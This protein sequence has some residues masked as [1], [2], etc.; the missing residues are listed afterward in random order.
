MKIV[1]WNIN[2]LRSALKKNLLEFIKSDKY[3]IIL[4]QEIRGEIVPLD[5]IMLGY[6]IFSFPAKR[7]GYSGVMTLS[8]IKPINV[9]KGI[10]IS[11]FDNEG[12]VITI[13]LQDFF[14]I[15][16]YFPRAGD[17]LSR[18]EFKL[19]FNNSIENFSEKLRKIKPVIICGDF[20]V[21]HQNIDAAYNDPSI[22]GLTPQEKAW[23]SHFLSLGYIDTFRYFHPNERKYSWWS[24]M[25]NAR[26]RNTGLRLDYC[27]V[28]KE[29]EGRIRNA[30]ILD[31]IL[32]S[33]HAPIIL[34]LV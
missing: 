16:S 13:E 26:E 17:N 12:R 5:F 28:S 8:V 3:D 15:N 4:F 29:L 25:M 24:F 23:F 7:K 10:G 20:N 31:N 11:E 34:E 9:I 21:A 32:G 18:L 6:N 1:S 14:I 30:D 33:D 2:G 27:L 19:N 22:P